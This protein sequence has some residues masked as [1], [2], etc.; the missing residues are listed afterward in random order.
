[1]YE[2]SNLDERQGLVYKHMGGCKFDL[3]FRLGRGDPGK[4]RQPS[5]QVNLETEELASNDLIEPRQPTQGRAGWSN[6]ETI[7]NRLV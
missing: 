1:M 5:Q 6:D 7:S 4:F 2:Y 3:F